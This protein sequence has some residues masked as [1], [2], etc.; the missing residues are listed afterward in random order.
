[1]H[2]CAHLCYFSIPHSAC[3]YSHHEVYEHLSRRSTLQPHLVNHLHS[4]LFIIPVLRLLFILSASASPSPPDRPSHLGPVI[5]SFHF[6]L[7]T[8]ALPHINLPHRFLS[9]VIQKLQIVKNNLIILDGHYDARAD[10]LD[11]GD[12]HRVM[13]TRVIVVWDKL[14][15]S[16]SNLIQPK[17]AQ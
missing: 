9:Y 16:S 6:F 4:F 11:G 7:S 15:F 2:G 3:C 5:F 17:S 1:M 13:V 14:P 8:F 12:E 10:G